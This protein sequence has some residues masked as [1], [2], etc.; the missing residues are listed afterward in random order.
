MSEIDWKARA[1]AAEAREAVLREVAEAVVA[2]AVGEPISKDLIASLDEMEAALTSTTD[3][4]A[5]RDARLHEEGRRE[6]VDVALDA[7]WQRCFGADAA[8]R[9][10]KAEIRALL[11]KPAGEDGR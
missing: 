2:D 3:A 6:G 4:A 7:M 8:P 11:N 5:A 1:D 10:V 9:N